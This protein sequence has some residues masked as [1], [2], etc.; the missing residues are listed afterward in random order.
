MIKLL[1]L[2]TLLIPAAASAGELDSLKAPDVAATQVAIPAPKASAAGGGRYADGSLRGLGLM[3]LTGPKLLYTQ[4]AD[5]PEKFAE[6]KALWAPVILKAGLKPLPAEYTAGFAA[7][8]YESPDGS[9]IRSFL[10]D[11]AHMPLSEAAMEAVLTAALRAE[12]LKLLGSYGLPVD[13]DIFT[14]PTVSL[15]YLTAY[16]KNPDQ[17]VQ[18][19]YLKS[20][21]G[22]AG[23]DYG[24]LEAAGIKIAARYGGNSMFYIGRRVGAALAAANSPEMAEKQTAYHKDLIAKRGEKLIGAKTEKLASPVTSEGVQYSYLTR[25]YYFK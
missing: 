3:A 20:G 12:G 24:I 19:R 23:L 6:F 7:L 2:F 22:A 11:T 25:I 13:E 9:A 5:T 18:L 10:C 1:A 4:L 15:Y 16:D 17:E 21:S 14:K 8:K